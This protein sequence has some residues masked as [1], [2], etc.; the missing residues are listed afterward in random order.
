MMIIGNTDLVTISDEILAD[1]GD[2][3]P[4]FVARTGFSGTFLRKTPQL[5]FISWRLHDLCHLILALARKHLVSYFNNC[6]C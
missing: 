5:V 2:P 6:E 1:H 4:P 3:R